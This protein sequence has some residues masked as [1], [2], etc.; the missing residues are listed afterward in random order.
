[1]DIHEIAEKIYQNGGKLYIVGGAVRDMVMKREPNDVDYCVV[2]FTEAEFETLF[3]EAKKRGQYFPVYILHESEF[4]LARKDTKTGRRHTEFEVETG[5]DVT[6]EEDLKRRDITMNS[7]AFDVLDK[8]LIDPYG[9]VEDIQNENIRA[10]SDAFSEDPLRIYR[11]ARFAAIYGFSVNNETIDMMNE[12]KDELIH[13][14][15]ERVYAELYKAFETTN[16][17]IFFNTLR[18]AG[19]LSVHFKEIEDLIGVIQPIEYHPEGDVY[20][21]TMEA[22]DRATRYTNN[23]RIIYAVLV[24]DLGKAKTPKGNL[25]HH[26]NHEMLG[27]EPIRALSKRIKVPKSWE[28]SG[29]I[30][31]KEHMRAARYG[32]MKLS[33]KVDF[34]TKNAR[35][36]LGLRGLEIVANSD[37][38]RGELIRFAKVGMSMLK[39]VTGKDIEDK[40][41]YIKLKETIRNNRIKWLKIYENTNDLPKEGE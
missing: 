15:A 33:T 27:E 26:Y 13:L 9:G 41:D 29:L 28:E 22:I 24:H 18:R 1:M 39:E 12:A 30:A 40:K 11:V 5:K 2:G 20:N 3:P 7:M 37:K 19:C 34:L 6:I 21:H 25:P 31:A 4:A 38:N 35:T 17:S 8:T 16:P 23:P 32:E 36:V 10:T 14:S